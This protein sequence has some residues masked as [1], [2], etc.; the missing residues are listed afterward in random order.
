M[1]GAKIEPSARMRIPPIKISIKINGASHSF[2]LIAKKA[3][4]SLINSKF[5][6]KIVF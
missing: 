5:I 3:K 4:S 1:K 2:F 6:L